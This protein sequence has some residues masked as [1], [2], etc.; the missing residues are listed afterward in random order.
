MTR[1]I[2]R[3]G[4]LAGLVALAGCIAGAARAAPA[5]HVVT[6]TRMAFAS[7]PGPLAVGDE[8]VW[9]NEDLFRHTATA[10]DGSFDLDLPPGEEARLTL[11]SAGQIEVFCRFHPGMTL[12]LT[13]TDA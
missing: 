13:V 4:A 9:R 6:I 3:R 1:H 12:G 5:T 11:A 8:I 2:S 7:P 10:R